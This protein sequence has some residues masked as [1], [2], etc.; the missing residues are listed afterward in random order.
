MTGSRNMISC[1]KILTYFLLAWSSQ[2]VCNASK[3]LYNA[4]CHKCNNR[5]LSQCIIYPRTDEAPRRSRIGGDHQDYQLPNM[6]RRTNSSVQDA[7]FESRFHA[8]SSEDNL[9][10]GFNSMIHDG[11]IHKRFN[12]I[13]HEEGYPSIPRHSYRNNAY[14]ARGPG[15]RG[16]KHYDDYGRRRS[17]DDGHYKNQSDLEFAVESLMYDQHSGTR[18]YLSCGGHYMNMGHPSCSRSDCI[19]RPH[20]SEYVSDNF[21]RQAHHYQRNTE[22]HHTPC[23]FNTF[24]ITVNT[25]LPRFDCGGPMEEHEIKCILQKKKLNKS[26]PESIL[27]NFI[28]F[29]KKS[30]AIYETEILSIITGTSCAYDGQHLE[31]K[32]NK[33]LRHMLKDKLFIISPIISVSVFLILFALLN[34]ISGVVITSMILSATIAYVWY[35][36]K[37][38]KRINKIYGVYDEQKLMELSTERKN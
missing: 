36:Y 17:D 35:K 26:A 8:L 7:H 21:D 14:Y 25:H 24:D 4:S 38:C 19:S 11:N 23:N 22:G 2:Y 1:M 20:V 3:S 30:D 37:K 6:S 34:V 13:M 31:Q 15:T 29:I 9:K 18:D 32:K 33:G 5:L 12:A 27:E 10:S 16:G 28:K